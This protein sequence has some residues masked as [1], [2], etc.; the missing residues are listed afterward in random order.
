MYCNVADFCT[1][2][3]V[4]INRF[5][6]IILLVQFL[7]SSHQ[8]WEIREKLPR[9]LMAFRL[10]LEHFPKITETFRWFC[11]SLLVSQTFGDSEGICSTHFPQQVQK[12]RKKKNREETVRTSILTPTLVSAIL[13]VSSFRARFVAPGNHN[14]SN[15]TERLTNKP[16][17]LTKKIK[18]N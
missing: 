15:N 12:E 10:I 7:A 5:T 13:T 2:I 3:I 17:T 11:V 9:F 14:V 8:L 1:I 6:G 16:T 18:E 4:I